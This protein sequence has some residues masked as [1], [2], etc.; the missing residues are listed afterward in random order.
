VASDLG[1]SPC[2]NVDFRGAPAC[3]RGLDAGVPPHPGEAVVRAERIAVGLYA[4]K[5]WC[6]GHRT[7]LPV[8][9]FGRNRA[10]VDGL[11]V[12]CRDC[13]REDVRRWRQEHPEYQAAVNARRRAT[14]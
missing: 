8:E 3:V 7:H 11:A 9:A 4:G 10:T 1:F 5:K 13:H 14:R 12:R 2:V 6:P